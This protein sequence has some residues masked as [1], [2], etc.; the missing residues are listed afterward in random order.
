VSAREGRFLI[1][2]RRILGIISSMLRPFGGRRGLGF[3]LR[4]LLY[5]SAVI[6]LPLGTLGIAAPIFYSSGVER[7]SIAYTGQ[8]I[9]QV[10]RNAEF[11]IKD[12]EKL[13]DFLSSKPAV[14]EFLKGGPGAPAASE[15][16]A[17]KVSRPEIAGLLALSAD[18]RLASPDFLRLSRDRLAKEK[19]YAAAAATPGKVVLTPRPVGRNVR[20]IASGPDEET[21]SVS[22]ACLDPASREILG[23]VEIDLDLGVIRGLLDDAKVGSEGF[24]FIVDGGGEPVLGP[25][26]PVIYRVSPSWIG[27][28]ESGVVKRVRG[29]DYE[30]LARRSAYTGW[31][32]VGVFSRTEVFHEADFVRAS[33]LVI[34]G[35]T[36]ALALL[37]SFLLASS[38]ARPVVELEGLMARAETGDFSARF[39]GDVADE[40]GRL[41]QSYNAMIAEIRNLIDLVYKEQHDKREAEL[42][43]LQEQIKPHFLYNTLET[44]R[45][46][47]RRRGATDVEDMVVA[48]TKLFRVG[49]SKGAETIALRDELDHAASYLFIQNTR[50]AGKFD[51]SID[52][53]EAV[54]GL[55]VLRLI[56]QPLAENAIYHG[57]KEKRDRGFIRISARESEGILVLSVEDDGAGMDEERKAA[58]EAVLAGAKPSPGLSEGFGLYNVH[59]RL[60][61]SFGPEFGI[62]FESSLG[63]GTR[64]DILHPLLNK[65]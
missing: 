60:R 35:I 23:V 44:I 65:G 2:A 38:V 62:R 18:D 4:L 54:L 29:E 16:Q 36:V 47:A 48:L 27:E 6:V 19:W 59:E 9:A 17:V 64:V 11:Y 22:K 40:V 49:L 63:G 37:L 15:M 56:I 42:H 50:Y 7:M 32:T 1:G 25:W 20:R 13:I 3:R 61:L 51:Y 8:M 53:D 57:I 34:G 52:A 24:L 30:I 12:V 10:T 5:F 45:Y 14:R 41:G 26:N 55:S 21:V 39:E 43:I 33:A 58:L 28:S 31:R 46:M